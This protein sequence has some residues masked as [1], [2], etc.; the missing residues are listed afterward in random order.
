MFPTWP[1]IGQITEPLAGSAK[2]TTVLRFARIADLDQWWHWI[3]LVSLIAAV[4]TFVGWL[5]RRDCAEISRPRAW[6]LLLLRCLALLGVLTFFLQLERRTERTLTKTS[7]VVVLADVSQSM[8]IRDAGAA[9]DPKGPSRAEELA[10]L[11]NESPLLE[12]LRAEHDVAAYTFAENSSPKEVAFMPKKVD[13]KNIEAAD[14]PT[15]RYTIEVDRAKLLS[16]IAAGLFL[17]AAITFATYFSLARMKPGTEG[18]ESWLELLTLVLAIGGVVF[19]GAALMQNPMMPWL[20][21][22]GLRTPRE[23]DL[24]SDAPAMKEDA[25]ANVL[26][27]DWP[28]TLLPTGAESRLGEAIRSIVLKERGGTIAGILVVSDGRSNAGLSLSVAA[29]AAGQAEIPIT[30]VGLGSDRR[31]LND[32]VVDLEAPSRVFPNDKFKIRGFVQAIG[33]D[34]ATLRVELLSAKPGVEE[35]QSEIKIDE[36]L[37][38]MGEDGQILPVEFELSPKDIGKVEYR[39]RVPLTTNDH[40]DRDNQRS[41]IVEVV[42][43]E[44]RVL[45]LAGGPSREFQFVRN[46]LFRDADTYSAVLLQ[47]SNDAAAQEADA[48]LTEFPRNPDELFS[49]DCIVAFDPDWEALDEEQI[50]LLER[51]VAERAGGLICIAGPVHTPIWSMPRRNDPRFT[52]LRRLYPVIFYSQGAATLGLD[53][54]GGE[55]P[56]PPQF[57]GDGRDAEFLAIEEDASDNAT[58]WSSFEGVYGYYAVK[59]PKPGAR[60][61]ARFSDP[62][63][64]LDNTLPIYMA[65]HF[66]GAGR[67]F[68]QASGEMWRLRAVRETY[69][70]QYYIKLIRWASQGRLSRD[71]ARGVLLVD[72]EKA[73]LGDQISVRAILTDPQFSPLQDENV[74]AQLQL[75]GGQVTRF[76][77]TREKDAA[78]GGT[79]SASFVT[80]DEGDYRVVL[81]IADSLTGESLIK[82]IRV[83]APKLEIEQAERNDS[84]MAEA[85]NLSKG[86]FFTSPAALLQPTEGDLTTRL[87]TLLPPQDRE[88]TLPSVLDRRFEARWMGWLLFWIAGALSLEWL[89]RR[90]GK[91][92]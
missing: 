40:N 37:V 13:A 70:D 4:V 15:L 36:R 29:E 65:G 61:Y 39:L 54:F 85:A 3:V 77:M 30:F 73:V 28:K 2:S 34:Q 32:R 80:I 53:Q 56:W 18:R 20:T 84:G 19:L 81:P 45:L 92:A 11:M 24:A 8:A 7:R 5:Y 48:V 52:I 38:P 75:P 14:S 87:R 23:S 47:S 12:T 51:W 83:R 64:K 21:A 88:T 55:K 17:L 63:T 62:A 41:A 33:R 82:T 44:S 25:Q 9:A 27:V 50:A 90:L 43:R 78:R 6:G 69:L 31:P 35:G 79:Y 58:A 49:Y 46:M 22:L 10:R 16:R 91:L 1:L 60:V 86:A 59:D 89:L 66:Y 74:E 26:N 42:E 71:S 72:K 76:P 67:V 57:T 68:F